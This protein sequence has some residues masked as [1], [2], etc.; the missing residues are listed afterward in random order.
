MTVTMEDLKSGR[1]DLAEVVDA[2]GVAVGAVHPGEHVRD[3][4]DETGITAY[5]LAK[6]MAVPG[7]RL[8]AI[9]A[10]RRAITADT[11]IRLGAATGTSAEMWLGLQ[12]AYDLEVARLNGVGADVRRIAA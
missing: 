11:A 8:L 9:L 7:N 10:G 3:W 1:I 4:L 6:A 12:A 5:A 2:A